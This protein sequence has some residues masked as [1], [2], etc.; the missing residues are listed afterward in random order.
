MPSR[1]NLWEQFP[2]S[3]AKSHSLTHTHVVLS[4]FYTV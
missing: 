1:A 2:Q 3:I 4:C